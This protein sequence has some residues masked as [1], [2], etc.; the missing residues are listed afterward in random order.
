MPYVLCALPLSLSGKACLIAYT[1]SRE[2]SFPHA[3]ERGKRAREN[4]T[5]SLSRE[6][7]VRF[8]RTIVTCS[9]LA[10]FGVRFFLTF[11]S[12]SRSLAHKQLCRV[13][14][15]REHNSGDF[16]RCAV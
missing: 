3:R 11:R 9:P 10:C 1:R 6:N 7:C 8:F 15:A 13:M 4:R 5:G 12:R 14:L 16:A 2:E